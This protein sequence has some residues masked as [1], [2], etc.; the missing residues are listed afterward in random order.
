MNFTDTQLLETPQETDQVY[1]PVLQG[2]VPEKLTWVRELLGYTVNGCFKVR[3][4]SGA[5]RIIK[6]Y[7]SKDKPGLRAWISLN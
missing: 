3:D 1:I 4:A 6:R 2:A 5:V 7:K